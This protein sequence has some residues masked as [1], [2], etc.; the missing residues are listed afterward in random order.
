[1]KEKTADILFW[2]ADALP[3]S[4]IPVGP[5]RDRASFMHTRVRDRK[6]QRVPPAAEIGLSALGNRSERRFLTC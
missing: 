1:M 6:V 4:T 5:E 2:F 3:R